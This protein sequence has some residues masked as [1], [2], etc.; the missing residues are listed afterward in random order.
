MNYT[1]F[2]AGA[3]GGVVGAHLVRAGHDVTF[4]DVNAEHVAAMRADGL[5]VSGTHE[6]T[7]PARAVTPDEVDGELGP[8]LL[9]VKTRHTAD[10]LT[11]I[12]PRLAPDGYV[13]SLQ[14]GLEEYAI[15]RAVGAERTVGAFL[16]FG[17]YYAGPGKVVYA[18][19]GSFRVGEPDGRDSARVADLARTL[20]CFHPVEPTGNIF[21]HLWGKEAVGAFY[22]A[23]ALVSEDVTAIID[24]AEYR[25]I[26][27][28]LVAEVVAVARAHGV[29]CEVI[30][31]FDPNVFA[32]APGDADRTAASWQAQQD[33][34]AGHVQQRTGVWRD[35]AVHHRPTEVDH[36]VR[37][38]VDR[39]RSHG[40]PTPGLELLVDMVHE[41]ESGSREL[42]FPNLDHLAR[43]LPRTPP[44]GAAPDDR[45]SGSG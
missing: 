10:A 39:A 35:L 2:G 21:G 33:Y 19:P 1:V 26:L 42:G 37:P 5:Q 40:V 25:P 14:N 41:V 8:V 28:A 30:D 27:G 18:G 9:A 7:V 13:V 15:A 12:A 45:A 44:E 3:I 11:A 38:I 24:R 6:F 4:V 22:F 34:W 43:Q 20:S 17:G 23:T 29:R 31:G 16:T 32:D 36:I